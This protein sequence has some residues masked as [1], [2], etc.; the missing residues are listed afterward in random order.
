MYINYTTINVF[1]CFQI[2]RENCLT[3]RRS[4]YSGAKLFVIEVLCLMCVLIN[5]KCKFIFLLAVLS[6]IGADMFN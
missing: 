2:L 3:V 1:K 4:K 5:V 6:L